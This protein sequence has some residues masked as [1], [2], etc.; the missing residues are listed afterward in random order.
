M[1]KNL[2][3]WQLFGILFIF[4]SGSILHFAFNLFQQWKPIGVIAPV[5]ESVWEHLKMGYWPILIF[6]LIEYR[7]LKLPLKNIAV[8]KAAQA[9]VIMI[10]I[11][12]LHYGY[13]M[14]LGSPIVILDILIFFISIVI[15]QWVSWHL[16]LIRKFPSIIYSLSWI[17]IFALM[18]AFISFTFNPPKLH[19]FRDSKGVYGI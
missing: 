6:G 14:I 9:L 17:I 11:V 19:L 5:N 13:R 3:K 4:F 18:A 12:V 1:E 8:A 2:F 15:G 7:A 10:L 16:I